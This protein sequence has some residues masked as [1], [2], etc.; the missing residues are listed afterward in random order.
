MATNPPIPGLGYVSD[1][2]TTEEEQELLSVIDVQPW[3]S[4]LKRRVQHYGYRYDYKRRSVDRSMYLGPL[5]EWAAEL[6]AGLVGDGWVTE[7]P[8][9]LIINE[10]LP[11]QG[12]LGHVDCIPCFSDTIVSIS[13]GSSCVMVFTHRRT[14]VQEPVLLEPR[15]LVVLKGEARYQ[16]KHGI[17]A[18][19][20][21]DYNARKIARGRRISLTFRKVLLNG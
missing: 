13:L 4:D 14:G 19:K 17:P 9:Q 7:R 5:P 18:R 10:Y 15:S 16:W 20:T 6:A 8:D 21:D 1:Y 11:G 12:I 2:L 3:L